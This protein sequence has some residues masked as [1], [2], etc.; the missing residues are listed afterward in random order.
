MELT[1]D[2]IKAAQAAKD[3]QPLPAFPQEQAAVPAHHRPP[4]VEY[5]D[6]VPYHYTVGQPQPIIVNL[7]E[8]ETM[9][10]AQRE[11]MLNVVMLLV[12][13]VVLCGCVAGLVV[14]CGGTLMGIIGAVGANAVPIGLTTIGALVAAGW[15]VSK[16]KSLTAP[17]STSGSSRKK[18]S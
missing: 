18:A 5:R 16:V 8:R 4:A 6:G 1:P 12:V 17:R 14:I 3:Q 9:S 13:A 7:P 15:L 2:I 11:L 10:P